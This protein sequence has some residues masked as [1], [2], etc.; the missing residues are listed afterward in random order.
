MSAACFGSKTGSY[1]PIAIPKRKFRNRPVMETGVCL[2]QFA[3]HGKAM[4]DWTL[5]MRPKIRLY[6]SRILEKRR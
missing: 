3:Y 6:T 1:L 5:L 2:V 4:R